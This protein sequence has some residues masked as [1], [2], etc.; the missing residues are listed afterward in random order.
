MDD[1]HMQLLEGRQKLQF[2]D[3]QQKTF[4]P[5]NSTSKF[6]EENGHIA[7]D[8]SSDTECTANKVV[9]KTS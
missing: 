1:D 5:S 9:E 4:A 3:M 2:F 7:Q 6:P 8:P